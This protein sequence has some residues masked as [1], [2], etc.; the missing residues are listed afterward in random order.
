M[1]RPKKPPAEKLGK[2]WA[3]LTV[4]EMWWLAQRFGSVA[5]GLRELTRRA[6]PPGVLP[7]DRI[8]RAPPEPEPDHVPVSPPMGKRP[9]PA[10]GRPSMGGKF[11]PVCR[12]CVALN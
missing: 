1:A 10:H 3:Y 7:G 11:S 2:C 5:A 9:C 12:Q 8:D 4:A 6:M